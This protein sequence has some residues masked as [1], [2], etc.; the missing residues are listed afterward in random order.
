MRNSEPLG[1]DRDFRRSGPTKRVGFH[2]VLDDAH[3]TVG[4]DAQDDIQ[5]D[6]KRAQTYK[7][8][9][10]HPSAL[11]NALPS[12]QATVHSQGRQSQLTEEARQSAFASQLKHLPFAQNATVDGDPPYDNYDS[13]PDNPPEF[14]AYMEE[15]RGASMPAAK[16]GNVSSP[17]AVYEDIRNQRDED[18][19]A[20]S[21]ERITTDEV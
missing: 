14:T 5:H 12:D 7:D 1:T 4:D 18:Q 6:V 10:V 16:R 13:R 15:L 3:K 19:D 2:P 17:T 11:R 21:S 8:V 9:V 20:M